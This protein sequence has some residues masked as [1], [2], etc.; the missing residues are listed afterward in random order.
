MTVALLVFAGVLLVVAFVGGLFVGRRTVTTGAPTP[1]SANA[2]AVETVDE[3]EQAAAVAEEEAKRKAREV[4]N[5]S[6][7]DT[8]S[9]VERLRALGRTAGK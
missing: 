2:V 1:S 3:A 9:D 5:A 8:R 6:D 7:A 4:L